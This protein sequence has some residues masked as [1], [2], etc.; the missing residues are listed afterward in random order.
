MPSQG[1][2]IDFQVELIQKL[3][4]FDQIQV[5]E[6]IFIQQ[7]KKIYLTRIKYS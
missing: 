3:S 4:L 1:P 2:Y 6:T 7:R 5:L